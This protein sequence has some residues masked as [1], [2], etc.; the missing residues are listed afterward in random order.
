MQHNTAVKLSE[1]TG[2]RFPA[3]K[4]KEG[5]R[6]AW[7]AD[8]EG[9]GAQQLHLLPLQQSRVGNRRPALCSSK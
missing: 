7:E 4:M 1:A 9:W 5:G 3:K 8:K 2:T 6:G